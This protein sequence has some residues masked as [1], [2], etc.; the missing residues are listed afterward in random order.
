MDN[1][2]T[3]IRDIP[4]FPVP[5]ILFRDITTM[6]K[7]GEAFHSSID[8]LCDKLRDLD[9]DKVVGIESRGFIFGAP[10]AYNL[11]A[12]FVP[13]R[14]LGKLPADTVVAE[15][16]LEYGSNTVEMHRDAITV[17]ERVVIVDDLLATGGTTRATIDL[18]EQLDGKIVAIA[19][20]IELTELGAR[21]DLPGYNIV[22]LI[23]Y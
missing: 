7:D 15:Y 12:G 2:T 8:G 19:F 23:R 6:L 10:I 20:L 17:G 4:D 14:K 18:I 22:T 11:R 16:D 21:Q 5:G 13:V 9:V 3:L 1:L